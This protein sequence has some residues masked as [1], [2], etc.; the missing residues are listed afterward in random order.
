MRA[1]LTLWTDEVSA[2]D[3]CNI[4]IDI[5]FLPRAGDTFM[6]RS[7][8]TD[9]LERQICAD[10]KNAEMHKNLFRFPD[11]C[12]LKDDELID[13]ID[14]RDWITVKEVYWDLF[15]SGKYEPIIVL[16]NL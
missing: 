11:L 5:N 16:T 8:D 3:S 6:L 15:A 1:F 12:L 7:K 9:K 13:K 4:E 2:V 14:I 10:R